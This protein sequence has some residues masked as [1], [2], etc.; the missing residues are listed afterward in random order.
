M[1]ASRTHQYPLV[2]VGTEVPEQAARKTPIFLG[3]V[4][5]I[6]PSINPY[7]ACSG[8]LGLLMQSFVDLK[9]KSIKIYQNYPRATPV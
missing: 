5:E 6:G 2:W 3:K 1:V 4:T 8:L 7:F 9:A